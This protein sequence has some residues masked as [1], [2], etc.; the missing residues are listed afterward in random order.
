MRA[1]REGYV[2]KQE[3]EQPA[4]CIVEGWDASSRA[5]LQEG[6]RLSERSP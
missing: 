3:R 1:Y 6:W 2:R 4:E 5:D